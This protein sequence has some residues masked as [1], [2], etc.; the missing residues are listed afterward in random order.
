MIAFLMLTS[1]FAGDYEGQWRAGFLNWKPC[2]VTISATGRVAFDSAGYVRYGKVEAD[3]SLR[4]GEFHGV[5]QWQNGALVATL[6]NPPVSGG[7]WL[8]RK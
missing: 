5:M 2:T 3:G 1:P 8:T 4:V 7:M 6:H